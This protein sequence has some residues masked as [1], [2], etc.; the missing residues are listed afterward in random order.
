MSGVDPD[1]RTAHDWDDDEVLLADLA[2]GL[3]DVTPLAERVAQQARG[4]LAWRSFDADLLVATLSFDSALAGAGQ[5]RGPDDGNRLLVFHAA[6]L[7]VELELQSDRLVGQLVP[8]G[9][10]DVTLEWADGGTTRVDADELGF[11]L[12]PLARRGSVR[13]HCETSAA[14]LVTDWF[15]L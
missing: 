15:P 11:F 7:S 1:H 13:L 4:A 8:P 12:V 3:R 14:R 10:G 6:P 5:T 9:P 2:R